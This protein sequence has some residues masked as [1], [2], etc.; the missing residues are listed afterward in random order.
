MKATE[1]DKPSSK[2][3]ICQADGTIVELNLETATPEELELAIT[4]HSTLE[5][6]KKLYR[7]VQ[8]H[9]IKEREEL[10]HTAVMSLFKEAFERGNRDGNRATDT[11]KPTCEMTFYLPPVLS[12]DDQEK[13]HFCN[14]LRSRYLKGFYAGYWLKRSRIGVITKIILRNDVAGGHGLD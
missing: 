2:A 13:I 11:E 7:D 9:K 12:L 3:L 6:V 10:R 14:A 4:D 1:S 5:T 8:E